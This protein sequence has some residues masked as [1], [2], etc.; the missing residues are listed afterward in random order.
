MEDGWQNEFVAAQYSHREQYASSA[1][2]SRPLSEPGI[3]AGR[4]LHLLQQGRRC[5]G[6][7]DNL[8][9]IPVLGGEATQLVRDV[10]VGPTFSP[11]GQRMAYLRANDPV[12]G[13]YLIL[14]ANMDG[15]DEKVIYTA[16]TP[17]PTW[18][19]WSP[20]GKLIAFI[21]GAG[22]DVQGSVRTLDIATGQ[23]H[24]LATLADKFATALAWMPDGRGLMIVY[25][26]TGA[27]ASTVSRS[28]S[29][30]F[31][32][33]NSTRSPTTPTAINP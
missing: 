9:R 32:T 30:P 12:V 21:Q 28:L 15:S 7:Q 14:S 18:L 4:K 6:K 17:Y 2:G 3:F 25:S 20:D 24:A 31:L 27:R 10:D 19:A 13:K 29:F 26:A 8:F 23:D 11:E 22:Q 16:P 1:A 5:G 33:G